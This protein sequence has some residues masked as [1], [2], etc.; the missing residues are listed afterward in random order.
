MTDKIPEE[1]KQKMLAQIPLGKLGLPED[2]AAAALFLASSAA[3]YITGQVINVNGGM[4][5][6]T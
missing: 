3:D 2:I 6:N 1:V 5:M 4:L